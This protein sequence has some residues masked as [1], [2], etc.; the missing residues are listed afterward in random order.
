[1]KAFWQ[2]T[3]LRVLLVLGFATSGLT[4]SVSVS[5]GAAEGANLFATTSTYACASCHTGTPNASGYSGGNQLRFNE[6]WSNSVSAFVTRLKAQG[7][8]HPMTTLGTAA[9]IPGSQA[10]IDV[11]D[12]YA[13]L[14]AKR[15]ELNPRAI[16]DRPAT[17]TSVVVGTTLTISGNTSIPLSGPYQWTVTDPANVT[18]LAGTAA[19]QNVTFATVGRY[20]INLTVQP[21][22]GGTLS[23][24]SIDIDVTAMLAPA[25]SATGF[26]ALSFAALPSGSQTLCP[27][28]EN[29]GTATLSLS[30]TAVKAAVSG[31]DYSNYFELGDNASCAATPRACNTS[32]PAGSP[33]SGSTLLQAFPA[34]SACTLA[35][36]FNPAKFGDAP[37]NIAA[38]SATLQVM[39][40]APAGTV[41]E[42]P[43][44][45]NLTIGFLSAS[46]ASLSLGSVRVGAQ[47]APVELRLTGAGSGVVR[48][49][50]MEAGAP[51]TV[52]SKTCPS[53]PFTLQ[54]GGDCTVTVTFTPTDAR[55]ASA[56]LRIS[57]NTDSKAVEVHLAGNGEERADV[58]GGGCSIASGNTLA[59]P[60][61]WVL[62]LLAIAALAHRRRT[63]NLQRKR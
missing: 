20:R 56:M 36:R 61:L 7:P 29:R 12:I 17:N 53:L 54:S 14:I 35:L 18:T 33:I 59:D 32:I 52:Q 21:V 47:S 46:P 11:A 55:A 27:T 60:T 3:I 43:M 19:T 49:T 37:N 45:G 62:V 51:F 42:F 39:H 57:T 50:A 9:E 23:S 13:F 22:A 41:A 6:L 5:A 16:I 4:L 24:T 2:R 10:A 40:N 58:S 1:M 44:T 15:D 48:V 31:A 34:D 63:R 28:I 38:R 26:N 8:G 25:F 30:F